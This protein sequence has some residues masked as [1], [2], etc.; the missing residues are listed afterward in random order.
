MHSKNKQQ[1]GV[2]HCTFG[3]TTTTM[4]IKTEKQQNKTEQ[5][6]QQRGAFYVNNN[7]DV[8]KPLKKSIVSSVPF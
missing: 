6:K 7:D 2:S 1:K 3:M 4:M 5:L 8:C